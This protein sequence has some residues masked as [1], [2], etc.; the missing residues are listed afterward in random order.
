MIVIRDLITRSVCTMY[1]D[2]HFMNLQ[3]LCTNLLGIAVSFKFVTNHLS[4]TIWTPGSQKDWFHRVATTCVL[5]IIHRPFSRESWVA[6]EIGSTLRGRQWPRTYWTWRGYAKSRERWTRAS[7]IRSCGWRSHHT[8]CCTRSTRNDCRPANGWNRK[9]RS[10][11][12][13]G[14]V[15]CATLGFIG[16]M[17]YELVYTTLHC[18]RY[19][20]NENVRLK[21]ILQKK[22]IKKIVLSYS[23]IRVV[24]DR[25]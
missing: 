16:Y 2:V 10:P 23:R 21:Y 7:G 19:G 8:A 17:I 11:H 18:Y 3:R 24:I 14:W 20:I 5:I 22:K 12:R 25:F 4:S 1:S 15:A 6:T 9:T 13:P